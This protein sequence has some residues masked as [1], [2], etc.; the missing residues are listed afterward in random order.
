ML[1]IEIND[2]CW[3]GVDVKCLFCQSVFKTTRDST[4]EYVEQEMVVFGSGEHWEFTWIC[5]NCAQE[6][7]KKMFL[8]Y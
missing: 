7:K 4:P 5:P 1:P 8:K 3:H 6:M 2:P